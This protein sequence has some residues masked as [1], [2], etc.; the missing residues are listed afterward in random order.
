MSA[1]KHESCTVPAEKAGY[2]NAHYIRKRRGRPMDGPIRKA[3]DD[4]ERFWQKV[5]KG[6]GCWEWTA[7]RGADGYGRF[8][9]D[10]T[11]KLAHRVAFELEIG[12]IPAG[13]EVDH[14]CHDR[15]CVNPQHLRLA[16]R[17]LNAQNM[18]GARVDS[19][20]GIRGVRYRADTGRWTAEVQIEGQKHYLGGFPDA[21]SAEAA[22]IAYRRENMP[23]S[24]M[25]REG[26]A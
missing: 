21:R 24:L 13:I 19:S 20:T 3:A 6:A 5:N 11:P 4:P 18:S 17:S 12:P 15:G 8:M 1:C 7:F 16:T 22:V 2:C 26:V 10:R 23:F 25:D 14:M 9:V